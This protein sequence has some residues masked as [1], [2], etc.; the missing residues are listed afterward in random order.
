MKIILAFCMVI[1]AISATAQIGAQAQQN[2]IHGIWKNNSADGEM[3]LMLNVDGTG[4]FDGEAIK[5]TAKD[6]TFTMIIVAESQTLIYSYNLQG[7][8][9][10]VSGGDL[11]KPVTFTRTGT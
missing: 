8:S 4:E 9:L 5:Y 3:T 7:N 11:E 10:T 2:K 1:A 6:N